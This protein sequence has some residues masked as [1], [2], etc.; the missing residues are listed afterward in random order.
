MKRT[1][2]GPYTFILPAGSKVPKIFNSGKKTIGIRV[3]DHSVTRALVQALGVP[4]V[5]TSVH[6][7]EN[8]TLEYYTD[9]ETLYENF[10]DRVEVMIDGGYGNIYPSTVLDCTGDEIICLREGAG[11]IENII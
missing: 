11:S 4:M 2:P 9:P 10:K 8:E 6:D 1:L 7:D 5:S 3:P